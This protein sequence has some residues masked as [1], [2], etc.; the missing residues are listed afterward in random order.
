MD[1][2]SA[3]AEPR[4]RRIIE[5][6]ASEGELSTKQ[7]CARFDIAPQAASQHLKVLLVAGLLKAERRS[8]RHIYQIDPDSMAEAEQWLANTRRQWSGRRGDPDK[9][10]KV[11]RKK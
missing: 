3:L 8:R 4:R 5:M 1:A 9:P 10:L 11:G 6:L 7:V 2:F